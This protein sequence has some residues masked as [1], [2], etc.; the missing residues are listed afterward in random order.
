M[1]HAAIESLLQCNYR[2]SISS[3][4]NI[5]GNPISHYYICLL[6]PLVF[7][8]E[9]SNNA[10]SL[11][12]WQ[13]FNMDLSGDFFSFYYDF[14]VSI[15]LNESGSSQFTSQ[16]QWSVRSLTCGWA[17]LLYSADN[18]EMP[19]KYTVREWSTGLHCTTWH[20]I[21]HRRQGY[22]CN[23]LTLLGRKEHWVVMGQPLLWSTPDSDL[24]SV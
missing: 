17:Q 9:V 4:T 21:L 19:Q 18:L 12:R 1:T 7:S 13:A 6:W 14:P 23:R 3:S 10:P 5:W 22:S 11:L 24:L 15:K 2:S 8:T 16:S 20:A